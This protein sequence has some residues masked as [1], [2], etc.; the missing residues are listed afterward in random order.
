[1]CK[2]KDFQ[3]NGF[4]IPEDKK[5]VYLN[6]LCP[7]SNVDLYLRNAYTNERNRKSFQIEIVKCNK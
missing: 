3:D 5:D 1:M 6:R 4:E 7:Q 2:E